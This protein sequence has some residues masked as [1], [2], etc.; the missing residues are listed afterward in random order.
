MT[1]QVKEYPEFVMDELEHG[2]EDSQEWAMSLFDSIM[3]HIKDEPVLTA[4]D[5][6]QDDFELIQSVAPFSE[7]T[8]SVDAIQYI[9]TIKWLRDTGHKEYKYLILEE[10][11]EHDVHLTLA[12]IWHKD[13]SNNAEK[14]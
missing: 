8:S 13:N 10:E 2:Y 14:E 6:W 9:D 11:T 4:I 12:Q 5:V 3:E 1:D 7:Y